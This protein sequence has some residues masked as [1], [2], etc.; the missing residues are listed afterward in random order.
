MKFTKALRQKIVKEFAEQNGGWFDPALFLATVR[1]TG[2]A[3]PAWEWF[4]WNDEKAALEHRLDQARDFA[5]G[6]TIR[7][8]IEEVHRGKMRITERSA[9]LLLSPKAK[10]GDG[11]GYY[12]TDPK[13]PEHMDELI[14]QAAQ[15][16]RWYLARYEAA[17]GHVGADVRALE[18]T[19]SLL[20]GVEQLEAA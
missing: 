16:M 6:L 1:E 10:R 2:E 15:S 19:L 3:H 7:F 14:R 11:G 20:N 12:T 18:A 5:R 9:P 4:E 13:N 8:Q 17:L